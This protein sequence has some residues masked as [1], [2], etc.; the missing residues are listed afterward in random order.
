MRAGASRLQAFAPAA[1]RLRGSGPVGATPPGRFTFRPTA[2]FAPSDTRCSHEREEIR[3]R[4]AGDRTCES[5][6]PDH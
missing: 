6:L 1:V 5:S 2:I 4:E 3:L